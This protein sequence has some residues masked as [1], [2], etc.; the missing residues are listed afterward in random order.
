MTTQIIIEK[1]TGERQ[2][3]IFK[4]GVYGPAGIP[5]Y[6]SDA[7]SRNDTYIKPCQELQISEA[8]GEPFTLWGEGIILNK[9][10]QRLTFI[11]TPGL[12][13][14]EEMNIRS[15]FVKRL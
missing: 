1:L 15:I 8:S 14:K 6:V 11:P 2:E 4:D 13:P 5:F 7:V 10:E 9:P 3:K 12:K